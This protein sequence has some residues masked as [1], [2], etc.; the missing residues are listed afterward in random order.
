[1]F[2]HVVVENGGPVRTVQRGPVAGLA[3]TALL[4]AALEVATG[5]DGAAWAVGVGTAWVVS[6]VLRAALRRHRVAGL[7]P[8]DRVT[9]VRAAL[10]CGVAALTAG[11]LTGADA[12][13]PLLGLAAG[14]LALDW[15]DGQVARRT[16]TASP[17]GAAF[18]ME[19][20]AFLVLVLSVDVAASAGPWVLVIGVARYLLLAAGRW[21]PWLRGPMPPRY[22]AKVVAALQGIVLTTAAAAVLPARVAEAA[23]VVAVG[24]LAVSFGHQ[25]WWLRT[26]AAAEPAPAVLEPAAAS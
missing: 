4:L 11:A 18:D 13:A 3:I 21:Q 1:V 20:D 26:H 22:W 14:A 17:F 8:A 10:S 2:L 7:G 15:V 25:V 6:L 5:L 9:L 12:R 23:L 19:V 24:A 16:G